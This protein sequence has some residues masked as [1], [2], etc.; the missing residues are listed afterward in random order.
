[1]AEADVMRGSRRR[2]A[3]LAA[4]LL[5]LPALLDCGEGGCGCGGAAERAQIPATPAERLAA[6]SARLP[7]QTDLAFF[8]VDMDGVRGS[9]SSL[10]KTFEGSLPLDVYRQEVKQVVGIDLLDKATYAGAGIHPDGGIAVGYYRGS[11][12][13]LLFV[14]DRARFKEGAVA[15]LKRHYRIE[16]ADEAVADLPGAYS[17]KGP[18]VEFAWLHLPGGMTAIVGPPVG[19]EATPGRDCVVALKEVAA[20]TEAASLGKVEGFDGF[21]AEVGEK[22]P[23]SIYLNTPRLLSI[24]QSVDPS[25]KVYQKEIIDTVGEQVRWAGAGGRADGARAEG[26]LF[27]GVS[28][29]TLKKFEGIDKPPKPSPRFKVMINDKA[30]AFVRTSVNAAQFWREYYGLMPERQKAYF[31]K[32]VGNLKSTTSI[33]VEKDLID[34]LTGNIGLAIYGVDPLML[35]ARRATE[36]MTVVTLAA[37]VQVK[38][39]AAIAALLDKLA[40]ELGGAVLK[41]QVPGGLTA[42]G[43]D[44]NSSTAPPFTL[45]LKDDVLTVASS[46]L[47]DERMSAAMLG[48]GPKLF[49]RVSGPATKALLEGEAS[50]GLYINVPRV[51]DQ[52]GLLAGRMLNKML[53]APQELV[54]SL[55]MSP[56]GLVVSGEMTFVGAG[57]PPE[58]PAE[59]PPAESPPAEAPAGDVGDA[60]TDGADGA[61]EGDAPGEAPAEAPAGDKGPSD[62]VGTGGADAGGQGVKAP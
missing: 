27:L 6:F 30:F 25:L 32:V 10:T 60:G 52:V 22:W 3:W 61:K 28:A 45:Y 35:M 39:P 50:T 8:L 53:A 14:E 4:A 7:A 54:V 19:A 58:P 57:A 12:V 17:V 46:R 41:R 18:G 2:L 23:A 24:Y 16:A 5:L 55:A 33:D 43:F 38:D 29:E 26:I 59:T 49:E 42:W 9:L 48:S 47:G 21:R 51:R 31:K 13:V 20:L 40:T 37:H 56:R 62:G 34:N 1:M 11:P 36:R 44:P 15:N